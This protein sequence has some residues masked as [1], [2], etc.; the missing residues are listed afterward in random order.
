MRTLTSLDLNEDRQLT[1][2]IEPALS[3]YFAMSQHLRAL[4]VHLVVRLPPITP[5]ALWKAVQMGL[6]PKPEAA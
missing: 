3:P 5:E 6:K 2:V 1:L 4:A